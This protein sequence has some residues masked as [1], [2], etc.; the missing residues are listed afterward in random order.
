[1]AQTFK[2]Q[3][4]LDVYKFPNESIRWIDSNSPF[5]RTYAIHSFIL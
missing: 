3:V 5:S 4:K 1:M 2:K